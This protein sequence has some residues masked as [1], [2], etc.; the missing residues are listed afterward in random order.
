[1]NWKT[2]LRLRW[3]KG[4]SQVPLLRMIAFRWSRLPPS[5]RALPGHFWKAFMNFKNYGLRTA[6]AL[7]YYAV[8]SVFPLILLVAVFISDLVGPAVAQ[9]RIAQGL[10]LFL[11]D[12]T[13]TINLV[14]DS[15]EQALQQ[16][17]SFGLVAL[18]G[19]MWSALG[20]LSN[21][22]SALDRI[23]QVPESRSL[24]A[25]RLLAFLMTVVLIVLVGM[26]FVTSGVLR[27]V[28]SF[29]FS[30]SSPWIRIGTFFLPL[31]LNMVIFVLLFRYVPATQVNWDAVWPAAILGGIALEV[32]K[33]A[34]A[35]YLTNLANFQIVYGSIATVIVL[36]L[37]AYIM[38]GIFL[39]SAEICAQLN[40]WF[41]RETGTM[42]LQIMPERTIAR[43]PAEVP[44]PM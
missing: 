7:S 10:I 30:T 13:E 37:W 43:L 44:P 34:F 6:A 29:F 32:G 8:F 9:E 2:R 36:M 40:L 17:S 25:E 28:E 3:S 31:G 26:S 38:S 18:I 15:I 14:H 35:W 22:T 5:T 20:L 16:S 11:P 12:E 39:V 42:R 21:L 4:L 27:L 33:A 23:F 19:L 1:M 41:T 24:W